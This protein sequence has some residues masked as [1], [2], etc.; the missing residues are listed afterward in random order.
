MS[1][2]LAQSGQVQALQ[3]TIRLGV[4][5]TDFLLKLILRSTFEGSELQIASTVMD[6]LANIHREYLGE[7]NE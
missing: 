5:D 7:T 2:V 3:K 4:K 1:K 6:K